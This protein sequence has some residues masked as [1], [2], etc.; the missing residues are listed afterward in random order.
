[1]RQRTTIWLVLMMIGFGLSGCQNTGRFL[2]GIGLPVSM[3]EVL[4]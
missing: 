2:Q 3:A 1:M 4:R